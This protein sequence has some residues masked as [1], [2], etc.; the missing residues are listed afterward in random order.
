MA[1]ATVGKGA[2][3]DRDFDSRDFRNAMGCFATGIAVISTVSRGGEPVGMTVNSFTSVSLDPPLVLYSLA[4]SASRYDAFIDAERFVVNVLDRAH[5]PLSAKFAT[6][7]V[8]GWDDVA[9]ETW[10]SG[11]PVLGDALAVFEC[12]TEARYEGGDHVIVLGRVMRVR[13]RAGG[14]PLLYY[15][16]TY[17]RIAAG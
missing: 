1:W 11:C 4:R 5:Q 9:F 10:G 14:D 13:H 17:S 3:A 7:G 8:T 12:D 15:R 6:K 16:G 2:M